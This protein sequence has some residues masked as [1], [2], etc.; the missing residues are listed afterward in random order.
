MTNPVFPGWYAD[1]ELH[2]FEGRYYIYPTCSQAYED[3]TFFEVWVS[4]DLETW[5]NEGVILDFKN[6]PWS[7]NRAAW[8]PTVLGHEGKYYFYF[9]AGDGAG[10]GV[11][12]SDS[13]VGPFHDAI[14][15]PL[16]A[17]YHH[18]AQPIDAHAFMDDDGQAYLYYGGWRHCV[19]VKLNQDLV[20]TDNTFTEITPP[21]Y[22]EGPFMLKRNG[23]YY[24]LWSNGNWTDSTYSV[25]YAKATSPYGPFTEAH[26]I[27][28]CNPSIGGG[29]GH[30]SVL[31][32]PGTDEWVM[33]YHR[34]PPNTTNANHRVVCLDRM[35]FNSQGDI[36]PVT[37]TIEG[38]TSA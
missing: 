27:M 22:V 26:R 34:R 3:Q 28:S 31:C 25:S 7:T 9:S 23:I 30:C 20:S 29:A 33:C 15:K 8:A 21:D 38:I 10:L 6:V 24:L 19:V 16:I 1:P 18:G 13:P 36:L 14:G 12:I 32:L 5:Q 2:F 11:A 4:N 17:D 37:A 35:I